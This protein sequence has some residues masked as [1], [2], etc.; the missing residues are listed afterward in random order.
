MSRQR[1]L[2]PI[3]FMQMHRLVRLQ[4]KSDPFIYSFCPL[5]LHLQHFGP[6]FHCWHHNLQSVS[7]KVQRDYF[8][9]SVRQ[10]SPLNQPYARR[11]SPLHV[12]SELRV[13]T[14]SLST[15]FTL[16]SRQYQAEKKK[17]KI[18][19]KFPFSSHRIVFLFVTCKGLLRRLRCVF[20][21]STHTKSCPP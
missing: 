7:T 5:S 20:I 10:R 17:R 6:K 16:S 19:P 14:M 3:M 11:S 15:A 2:K 4:N 9:W 18:R 21:L 1:Y 13:L 8:P 12:V